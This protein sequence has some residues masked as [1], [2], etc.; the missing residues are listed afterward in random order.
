MNAEISAGLYFLPRH[1][2]PGVAVVA[3]YDLVRQD[4]GGLLHLGIVVTSADQPLDGEDR[5]LGF[6]TA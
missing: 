1:L 5:V 4:L 6:V 2:D 3:A